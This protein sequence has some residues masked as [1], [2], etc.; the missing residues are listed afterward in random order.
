[1][2]ERTQHLHGLGREFRLIERPIHQLHPAIPRR[3]V[4]PRYFR[5]KAGNAWARRERYGILD[6][7]SGDRIA[8][9]VTA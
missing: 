2:E 3:F 6:G 5:D 8:R 9:L 7:R 4:E 1:M